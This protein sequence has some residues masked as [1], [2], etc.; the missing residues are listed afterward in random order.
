MSL[1]RCL[2]GLGILVVLAAAAQGA[3]LFVANHSFEIPIIDPVQNPFYAIPI[4]PFWTELDLDPLYSSN[5]GTFLNTEPNSPAGDHIFNADGAQ[6]AFLNT[7]SGNAFLQTLASVFQVGRSYRLL[8][9][10]CPSTRF[11][12]RAE[13]PMDY[14][15]IGF[16]AGADANDF[17]TVLVPG[18]AIVRNHLRTFTLYLPTVQ[19]SDPWAG[20]AVGIAL[21]AVGQGGGYWDLDNVRVYEY[22]HQ[23]D[24]T[25]DGLVNL[26]D[27]AVLSADWLKQTWSMSD[28]TGDGIVDAD[29][30]ILLA[31]LWLQQDSE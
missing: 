19:E 23:P 6:L 4:A 16:Y 8:V 20:K 5:T 2:T 28:L 9:D 31:D 27:F 10:V 24:L 29:D 21:R 25:N 13:E 15:S 14:L 18:S 3:S 12:P 1:L 22:P 17:H 30:L 7:A 26:E 11:P